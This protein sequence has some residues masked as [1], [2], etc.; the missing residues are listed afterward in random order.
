MQPCDKTNCAR[1][2]FGKIEQNNTESTAYIVSSRGHELVPSASVNHACE[3]V[4][5][6]SFS[7]VERSPD[8]LFFEE[9]CCRMRD[10]AAKAV[11][12]LN[13]ALFHGEVLKVE[14]LPCSIV[15]SRDF[16]N[17]SFDGFI[18]NCRKVDV[19]FCP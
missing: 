17:G 15:M 3:S 18:R 14:L 2:R 11:I 12:E 10:Y 8:V 19:R 7:R 1:A 5:G 13:F 9:C 4:A 16:R 6:G